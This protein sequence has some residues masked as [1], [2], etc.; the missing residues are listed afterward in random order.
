MSEPNGSTRAPDSGP[1]AVPEDAGAAA[2]ALPVPDVAAPDLPP[3]DAPSE[4]LP[5]GAPVPVDGTDG[6]SPAPAAP[7]T[8]VRPRRSGPLTRMGPWAPVAGGLVGV[9]LGV[10]AVLLLA[11][12]AHAFRDRLSL[13]FLVIGLG[14]LGASGTL[15]A[16]EVRLV[17]WRA[18]QAAI[19]P[20]WVEATAGLLDGL[21][22]ARLLLLISAFALFLSAFLGAH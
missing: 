21:T 16:D 10:V 11:G 12:S 8:T 5:E 4:D 14:L 20:G 17:R 9:V 19:A 7:R 22:P 2:T 15:L 3:V 1:G 18:R 6:A 13:V